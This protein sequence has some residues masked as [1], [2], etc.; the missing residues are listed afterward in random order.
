MFVLTVFFW[1]SRYEVRRGTEISG[2]AACRLDTPF[3]QRGT[4]SS[5]TTRV[6][7]S[8]VD[9]RA[10]ANHIATARRRS[11]PSSFD[12]DRLFPDPKIPDNISNQARRTK[13]TAMAARGL[14]GLNQKAR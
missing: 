8:H 9:L 4:L 14:P 2:S 3:A 12:L 1:G 5:N 13:S 11:A 10:L 7:R 6:V